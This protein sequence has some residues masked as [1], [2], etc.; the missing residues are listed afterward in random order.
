MI[1]VAA[2]AVTSA[3]AK[4]NATITGAGSTFVAPLVD[5][6]IPA[7]GHAFGDSVQYSAV[8][9]GAGGSTL[10]PPNLPDLV[11]FSGDL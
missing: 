8:G 7:W 4:S 3:G 9:S 6:W 1:A 11:D 10:R 2:V 5:A